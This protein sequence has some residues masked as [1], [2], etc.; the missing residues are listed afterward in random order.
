MYLK[1]STSKL[2]HTLLLQVDTKRK[3]KIKKKKRT[4]KS[5][6]SSS[7]SKQSD[8]SRWCR[9]SL[10]EP[11]KILYSSSSPSS[12][13]CLHLFY[14]KQTPLKLGFVRGRCKKQREKRK[15]NPTLLFFPL[16]HISLSMSLQ[17]I[18]HMIANEKG[19]NRLFITFFESL[20]NPCN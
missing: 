20:D 9:H 18:T 14:S 7:K 13:I 10:A 5:L 15:G 4:K 2:L 16:L 1:K 19:Y 12:S 6:Y 17:E 11:H 8:P 3:K